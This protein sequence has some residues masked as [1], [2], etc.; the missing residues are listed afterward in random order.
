MT[1]IYVA[2]NNNV[3]AVNFRQLQK[4]C[5][6]RKPI[7]IK[8]KLIFA[9]L[10]IILCTFTT[11]CT[12]LL[13]IPYYS[14]CCGCREIIKLDAYICINMLIVLLIKMDVIFLVVDA[15][16]SFTGGTNLLLSQAKNKLKNQ[17]NY[18]IHSSLFM[19]ECIP[20]VNLNTFDTD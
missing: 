2:D 9:R 8:N 4:L 15:D 3:H 10:L 11:L 1:D 18:K 17:D 16:F 12:L 13:L 6:D 14:D 5:A 20:H 7:N 19:F